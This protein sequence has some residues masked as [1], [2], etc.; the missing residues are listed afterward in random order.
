[1]RSAA[2]HVERPYTVQVQGDSVTVQDTMVAGFT[3][4]IQLEEQLG[5]PAR[6][7]QCFKAWTRL[8]RAGAAELSGTELEQATAWIEAHRQARRAA[9]RFFVVP[10]AKTFVLRLLEQLPA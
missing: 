8:Q 7:V 4:R 10:D 9:R 5:T 2:R 3:Y 6:V 1:M